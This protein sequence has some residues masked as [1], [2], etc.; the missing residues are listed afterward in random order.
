MPVRFVSASPDTR[1]GQPTP[2][3]SRTSAQYGLE[4]FRRSVFVVGLLFGALATVI[5][6]LVLPESAFDL[7][8]SPVVAAGL[9]M[10]A[11]ITGRRRRIPAGM[12]WA[13]PIGV[14]CYILIRMTHILFSSSAMN[15]AEEAALFAPWG[16]IILI[17]AWILFAGGPRL[18]LT[19][20]G[21]YV[22]LLVPAAVYIAVRPAAPEALGIVVSLMLSSGAATALLGPLVRL[23][24]SQARE[25]ALRETTDRLA[26]TDF[27]TGLPN[28]RWLAEALAHELATAYRHLRPLAVILFDLDR[29]KRINDHF[30]HQAGD[31]VLVGVSRH[32]GACVR[33]TDLFGRWGGEEFLIIA[34]ETDGPEAMVLA[35]RIRDDLARAN[36][37]TAGLNLTAS[38]GVV[39]LRLD[40]TETALLA[41]ADQALYR[42]K[43][44]G[45]DCVAGDQ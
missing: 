15:R 39:T 12:M 22:A 2:E 1:G 10:T 4:E 28:R 11:I 29:F 30:G 19:I 21:Y 27:L 14:M 44:R 40:D 37:S 17:M 3:G 43:E 8:V 38:F 25:Q 26:R 45:R 42:A 23:Q 5:N 20:I 6:P 31:E 34:P 36:F 13:I 41:R 35:T 9:V 24:E 32:V 18:R 16:P 7:I 33:D